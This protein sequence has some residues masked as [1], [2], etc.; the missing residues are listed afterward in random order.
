MTIQTKDFLSLRDV[1]VRTR[2]GHGAAFKANVARALPEFL[3][4]EALAC[5]C[6]PVQAAEPQAAEP[7]A[8][9]PQA[10]G[11]RAAQIEAAVGQLIAKGD[12]ADFTQSGRPR[13]TAVEREAGFDVTSDEVSA[14]FD[15]LVNQ[16]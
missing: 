6:V 7:Q 9:E 4:D 10:Q 14:A 3:W 5:G 13:V 16:E 15:K 12:E 8:A 1:T 2:A 11:D